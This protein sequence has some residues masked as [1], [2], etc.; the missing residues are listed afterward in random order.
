MRIFTGFFQGESAYS[1]GSANDHDV[2]IGI[3]VVNQ[4]LRD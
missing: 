4:H 3:S 2:P 1:P